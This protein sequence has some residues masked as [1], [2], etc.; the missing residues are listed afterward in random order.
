MSVTDK[1]KAKEGNLEQNCNNCDIVSK[2]MSTPQHVAKNKMNKKNQNENPSNLEGLCKSLAPR[3]YCHSSSRCTFHT[4]TDTAIL[5]LKSI[6]INAW[7]LTNI[8]VKMTKKLLTTQHIKHTFNNE[9]LFQV[10]KLICHQIYS[11]VSF[12]FDLFSDSMISDFYIIV[13]RQ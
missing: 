8:P 10:K 9:L 5:R 11:L 6:I 4:D 7:S 3:T 12:D 1:H 2:F 13:N